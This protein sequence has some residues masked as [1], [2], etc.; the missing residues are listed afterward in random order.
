MGTIANRLDGGLN[1]AD[2]PHDLA[3]LELRVAAY[4]PQNGVRP[5][6]A[7]GY[8]RVPWPLLAL[9]LGQADLRVGELEPTLGVA[10][11]A[12]DFLAGEL[13]GQHRVQAF[14]ALGGIAIG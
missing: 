12:L 14:D 9:G 13:A 2:Q 10:L 3:V 5:V 11:G 6:L 8:R 1:G 4:Q 7:P